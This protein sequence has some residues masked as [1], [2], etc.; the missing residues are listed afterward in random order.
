[1]LRSRPP[2]PVAQNGHAMPQPAWLE[3]QI[4]ARSVYR[5][6]TDSTSAPSNSF[7]RFLTVAPLSASIVRTGL[8]SVGSSSSTMRS[9]LAAGRSVMLAG[10]RSS[11]P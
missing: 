7:Q 6:S 1:M 8:S 4:V 5:I 3:T 11:R 10:S 2:W 9:R